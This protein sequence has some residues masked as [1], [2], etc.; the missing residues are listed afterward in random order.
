MQDKYSLINKGDTV[1]LGHNGEVCNFRV[2]KV[3]DSE[4]VLTWECENVVHL[5]RVPKAK[6]LKLIKKGA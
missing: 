2:L 4:V 1:W 5:K 6:L 3:L